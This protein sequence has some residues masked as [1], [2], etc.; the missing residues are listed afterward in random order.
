MTW[1]LNNR[2]SRAQFLAKSVYEIK[3]EIYSCLNAE[4]HTLDD[5]FIHEDFLIKL[6]I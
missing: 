4:N 3:N 2:V 5:I 1:V 6:G